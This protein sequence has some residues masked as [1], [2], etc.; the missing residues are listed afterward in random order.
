VSRRS[1]ILFEDDRAGGFEPIGLTRSVARL[2]SG[3]FTHRERWAAAFPDR[4]P[5]LLTRGY[6]GAVESASGDWSAV[7]E[8]PS[9]DEDALFV[10][11]A[12][13]RPGR[14]VA[15]AIRELEP[16]R[17]LLAVGHL[18]AARAAGAAASRLH[19]ILAD[20]AG[21]G[22]FPVPADPVWTRLLAECGLRPAIVE[23]TMPGGAVDLMAGNAAVLEAD[24]GALADSSP[25]PDPAD[26]PDVRFLEPGRIR[27]APG[28]RIDPGAVL[29]ARE[30]AIVI[31]S[32]CRVG[33][34]SVLTGP[35]AVGR[36]S[37]VKP[38][39]RIGEGTSLGPVSRVGG[40][41]S[42]TIVQ[43][44]SNKQHDGFVGHSYLGSWVNLGAATDTSDLKNDY[45]PVRIVL[46]GEE[47]GTGSAHV[48]SLIGD[49]SKTGIH[50]QLN[51]GTVVGVSSNLFGVGVPPREVP[52]FSW[53]G[54]DSWQEYRL[55]KAVRVARTVTG[56]RDVEFSDAD[57][58][59]FQRLHDETAPRRA[60]RNPRQS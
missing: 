26:H 11:A 47:I 32:G 35:L 16:G 38:L 14:S 2:R 50:T 30:G 40:E 7:N 34:L 53:G 31:G 44:W 21:D 42:A 58:K 55:E 59:L 20:L 5:A 12:L 6:L 60:A 57:A 56:R 18:V 9:D 39:S 29:D 43:G 54:G 27:V 24:F 25:P 22:P 10:A 33:A 41:M 13:G 17:A 51:T 46:N 4:E 3:L 52:S 49:H 1:L 45:G 28:V 36:D 23:T 37:L 15:A 8:A 48:G 19:G